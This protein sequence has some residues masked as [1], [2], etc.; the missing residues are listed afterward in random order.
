MGNAL[1]P[2]VGGF[3]VEKMQWRWIF[4][5][6]SAYIALTLAVG[7]VIIQETFL[8]LII[9]RRKA[10]FN[11]DLHTLPVHSSSTKPGAELKQFF[12]VDLP[13]P[14][15]MLGTQPIIQVL[16]LYSAYLFGLTHLLTSTFQTLWTDVYNESKSTA[17]L[18][19]ISLALGAV[20]G[21]EIAGP[22]NDKVCFQLLYFDL[23]LA[24]GFRST[25]FAKSV[26]TILVFLNSVPT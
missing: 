23:G 18:H 14:F 5:A 19:Y 2:I 1:G 12:Q 13:R 11:G 4:W 21:C 20:T 10:A 24:D 15:I 7:M 3:I 9:K 22:L 16:A 26:T 17:S 8:P 6:S 25:F